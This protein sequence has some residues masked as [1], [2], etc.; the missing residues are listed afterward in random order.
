MGGILIYSITTYFHFFIC[1]GCSIYCWMK[2]REVR[3]FSKKPVTSAVCLMILLVVGALIGLSGL[4]LAAYQLT[5]FNFSTLLCHSPALNDLCEPY[6]WGGIYTLTLMAVFLVP[7][8]I[9][10]TVPVSMHINSTPL[11]HSNNFA[12]SYP[13]NNWPLQPTITL[14]ISPHFLRHSW[15]P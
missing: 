6:L 9:L 10:G 15:Y 5:F 2:I 1:L 13:R 14:E 12:T 4:G 11:I 3:N 8:L 7:T